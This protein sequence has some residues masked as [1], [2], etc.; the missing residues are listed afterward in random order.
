MKKLQTRY[1]KSVHVL[2]YIRRVDVLRS[3]YQSVTRVCN[4][5]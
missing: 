5:I 3:D 1:R 2:S 4:R